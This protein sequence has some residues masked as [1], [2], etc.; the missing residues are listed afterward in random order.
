[1]GNDTTSKRTTVSR[2][3][4]LLGSSAAIITFAPGLGH[5]GEIP[6]PPQ[7]EGPFY[8]RQFPLDADN[9]LVSIAGHQQQA[10]GQVLYVVGRI[11]DLD[12]KPIKGAQVEIWQCDSY[13]H[14]HHV[15][16]ST[17]GLDADFQGY[18]R[19][20]AERDG[21]YRFRTIRPVPY[22]GRTPHI[23][24][25]VAAPGGPRLTTQMYVAGEKQ[26]ETDGVLRAIRDPA[27]R[28]RVIVPLTSATEVESGALI[29]TFDIVLG[30]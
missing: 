28:A 18:G 15:G 7:T 1:M 11:L 19:T 6:T 17:A 12:A 5:A 9:D 29:G 10:R 8:P 26:N 2:R 4:V 23:H 30:A 20:V 27:A 21:A 14:Y 16:D 25:T 22:P 3:G 13:G 24:F